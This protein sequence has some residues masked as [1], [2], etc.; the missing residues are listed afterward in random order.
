MGKGMG[1]VPQAMARG[2]DP[3][4]EVSSALEKEISNMVMPSVCVSRVTPVACLS[5][6][7]SQDQLVGLFSKLSF[8]EAQSV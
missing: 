5:G 7:L 1:W 4:C 3:Y 8:P 6:R 2:E